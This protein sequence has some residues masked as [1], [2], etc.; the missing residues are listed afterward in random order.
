MSFV[1]PTLARHLPIDRISLT[2]TQLDQA[3]AATAEIEDSDRQWQA[4]LH[5]LASMG[6]ENWLAQRDSVLSERLL[7]VIFN[8]SDPIRAIAIDDTTL[9]PIATET[10]YDPTLFIPEAIAHCSATHYVWVEVLEELGEV[11]IQGYQPSAELQS[12]C[13]TAAILD[14]QNGYF[15]STDTFQAD[16]NP[17]L[18][19]LRSTVSGWLYSTV[20][21]PVSASVTES[22]INVWNW[23][24]QTV[25]PVVNQ[26]S[27]QLTWTLLPPLQPAYGFRAVRSPLE[28]V[29]HAIAQLTD[30]GLEIPDTT[31]A[32]YRYIHFE[33]ISMRL[34]A[35]AWILPSNEWTLL[36]I[37]SGQP[38]GIL[39]YGV[40]LQIRD[41]QQLLEAPILNQPNQTYLY[42][43]VIGEPTER[44]NVTVQLPNGSAMI[45]PPFTFESSSSN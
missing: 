19:E 32:A 22:V 15:I 21:S 7:P 45:L 18:L 9:I 33:G 24:T 17:L 8:E 25:T 42:A 1:T 13:S 36:V 34:Y 31:C 38:D 3:I 12:H 2:D 27:E 41:D 37:L 11:L 39:P 4:Y 10:L 28:D 35:I 26:V 5:Y 40:S 20:E 30:E 14:R 6:L 43:Q 16:V 29:T 23:F 44:F